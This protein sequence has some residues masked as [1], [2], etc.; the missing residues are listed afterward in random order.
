[1]KRPLNVGSLSSVPVKRAVTVLDAVALRQDCFVRSCV[2]VVVDVNKDYNFYH[3][4]H[5]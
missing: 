5:I 2:N 1:M 3:S 4:N